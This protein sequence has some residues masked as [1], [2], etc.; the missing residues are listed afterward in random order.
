MMTLQHRTRRSIACLGLA[1]ILVST[2]GIAFAQYQAPVKSQPDATEKSDMSEKSNPEGASNPSDVDSIIANWSKNVQSQARMLIERYG[3]PN[4]VDAIELS[5]INNGPW[6]KT[7][8][9]RDGFTQSMIGRDRDHLEQTISFKVPE[10]KIADL[11]RFDKRIEVNQTVGELTSH[12]DSESMNF[13]AL[14]LAN[15]IVTGQ[16]NVQAARTF[17]Q[18]V[19]M[20]EKVGKSSPYLN[21]FVFA[22]DNSG[23]TGEPDDATQYEGETAPSR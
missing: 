11:Q 22:L 4:M 9:H 1:A 19:K 3:K 21:G 6:R 14:N 23:K 16:R 20:F 12:A 7:V 8:L 2:T 5:W 15:D 10:D 13:L 18:K 17:Y